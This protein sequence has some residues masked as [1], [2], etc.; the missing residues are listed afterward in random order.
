[1]SYTAADWI[2]KL[3]LVPLPE[4]G[5]LYRELYRS[6]EIIPQSALPDRFGGD[7]RYCTSI[8]Y[9]L[10]NPEFSAFHRIRQEEIWHFYEG[11]SLTLAILTPQGELSQQKLGRNFEAGE[12]L[13]VVIH[14]GDLF[15][16]TVDETGGYSLVGCTVAP[17]FEFADFEA[18]SRK[19]LLQAY[20]QHRA[21][22]ER[23]TR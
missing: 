14:R 15:A 23:L 22:I 11:S 7:R 21:V 13:Q 18:P 2:E 10:E 6:D 9:L 12:R 1:M 3:D 19:A 4:E 16:A 8:Y 20:P 17:G 5:G